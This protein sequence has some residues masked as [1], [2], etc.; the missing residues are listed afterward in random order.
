[1][2]VRK[3]INIAETREQLLEILYTY[4]SDLEAVSNA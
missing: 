1:M 4:A 2:G 3:L